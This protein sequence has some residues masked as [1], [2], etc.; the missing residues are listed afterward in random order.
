M[1]HIDD[2]RTRPDQAGSW[3]TVVLPATTLARCA[4]VRHSIRIVL[5]PWN[6]RPTATSAALPPARGF[7]APRRVES[8]N[9]SVHEDV[10]TS[11]PC[12]RSR[13]TAGRSDWRPWSNVDHSRRGCDLAVLVAT[14]VI[15]TKS[16]VVVVDTEDARVP[17]LTRTVYHAAFQLRGPRQA[18]RGHSKA[19]RLLFPPTLSCE[20][21]ERTIGNRTTSPE[22]GTSSRSP[23]ASHDSTERQPRRIEGSPP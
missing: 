14:L 18:V 5:L 23:E 11:T 7:L 20:I 2:A 12:C 16:Q 1:G 4:A 10:S 8:F 6:S 22:P 17:V 3:R 15:T 21:A 9:T 13:R 19:A